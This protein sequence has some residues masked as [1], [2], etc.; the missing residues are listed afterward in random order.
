VCDKEELIRVKAS[1]EYQLFWEV[2]DLERGPLSF[3][4]TIVEL[5]GR[6]SSFSG[7]EIREYGRRD[8]SRWPHGTFYPQKLASTSSTSGDS[9]DGIVRSRTKATE[10]SFLHEEKCILPK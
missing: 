7:L 6:K 4:T 3:V 1:Q 10:F 5:F 8:Q 9:S 2:V